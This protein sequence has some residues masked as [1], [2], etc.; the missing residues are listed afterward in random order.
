MLNWTFKNFLF[1]PLIW[2]F[3][4]HA[5]AQE[6]DY[7]NDIAKKGCECATKITKS[8]NDEGFNMEL[9]LCIIQAAGDYKAE[10]KRDYKVDLAK[11]PDGSDKLWE[12]VGFQMA[13]ICPEVF[14]EKNEEKPKEAGASATVKGTVTYIDREGFVSFSVK[15]EQEKTFKFYWQGGIESNTD[16]TQNITP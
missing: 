15:T 9:G 14:T 4:V 16:I 7:M 13:F 12:A 8:R 3:C 11:K 10:I 1:L 5:I 6:Q 2:C